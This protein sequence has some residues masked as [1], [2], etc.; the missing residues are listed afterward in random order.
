MTFR[1]PALTI[2]EEDFPVPSNQA[3]RMADKSRKINRGA[4]FARG[5]APSHLMF[6]DADDCVSNRLAALV[7]S[8]PLAHG[9]Y[10]RTGYLHDQHSPFVFRHDSFHLL[11][12]TS[13]IIRC[14]PGDLPA[15][16]GEPDENYWV[17]SH[18]H[19]EMVPFLASRGTPLE[20]LPFAGALY[21]TATG[22]NYSRLVVRG[23]RGK[24]D[25]LSKI[26]NCRLLSRA[27]R[28]EFGFDE[29]R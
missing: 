24:R 20:P 21:N 2:I 26:L 27:I 1:H 25:A 8:Q 7:Q 9:W 3:E 23:W 18:G 16:V 13:H 4:V 28:K 10:L 11:C 14:E 17:L 22:E 29:L 6:A 19:P 5:F 12:G 15:Q